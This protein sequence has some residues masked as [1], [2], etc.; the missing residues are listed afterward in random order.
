MPADASNLI[1]YKSTSFYMIGQEQTR[2]LYAGMLWQGML[3][4]WLKYIG[5]PI[6][7]SYHRFGQ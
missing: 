1:A 4:F 5:T 7:V 6:P 3:V 2:L